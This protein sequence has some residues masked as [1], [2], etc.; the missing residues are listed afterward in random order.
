MT[1]KQQ[2]RIIYLITLIQAISIIDFMLIMPLGPFLAHSL[3]IDPNNIGILAG[4][5]MLAGAV[6]GV[7]VARRLDRFDRRPIMLFLLAGLAITTFLS[8]RC[9]NLTTLLSLRILAGCFGGPISAMVLAIVSDVIPEKERGKAISIVMSAM[10][11]SAIIGVP[12]GLFLANIG[13]W[14][15]PFYLTSF[16]CLILFGLTTYLL[17]TLCDHIKN[18]QEMKTGFSLWAALHNKKA[19]LAYFCQ[20][21]NAMASFLIVPNMA[22]YFTLNLNFPLTGLSLLYIAAGTI[23]FFAMQVVGRLIDKGYSRIILSLFTLTW[24]LTL[25]SVFNNSLQNYW[26]GHLVVPVIAIMFFMMSNVSRRLVLNTLSSKV[27]KPHQRA[28]YMSLQVSCVNLAMALG[29]IGS[30]FILTTSHNQIN[31]M[32]DLSILASAL[33]IISLYGGFK[34]HQLLQLAS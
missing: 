10:S 12:F 14:R 3:N 7:L 21:L 4:S 32:T 26:Q 18:K 23:S 20:I 1:K 9:Y 31:H 17:P 22:I 24:C 13:S 29:A 6:I 33:A 2:Y 30:T 8:T 15:T 19:R 27:P 34:L 5:Y 16:L 28:G 11:I 25:L